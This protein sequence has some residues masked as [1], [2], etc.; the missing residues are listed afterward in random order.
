MV[1]SLSLLVIVNWL[2]LVISRT[3]AR[4]RFNR[5][6][7]PWKHGLFDKHFK[8]HNSRL[9]SLIAI[10][11]AMFSSLTLSPLNLWFETRW[12]MPNATFLSTLRPDST[13]LSNRGDRFDGARLQLSRATLLNMTQ[14]FSRC[15]TYVPDAAGSGE[16]KDAHWYGHILLYVY[17]IV[18][19]KEFNVFNT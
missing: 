3:D 5:E 6:I 16:L 12:V 1:L 10:A 17:L 14:Q 8:T 15:T 7:R 19:H 9:D 11:S 4:I 2:W 13:K 18:D